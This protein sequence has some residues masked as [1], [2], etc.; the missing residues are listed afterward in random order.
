MPGVVQPGGSRG[1]PPPPPDG[2]HRDELSEEDRRTLIVGGWAQD[3]KKQTM[4]EESRMF[5][6]RDGVKNLVDQKELIVWGPRR[7]FGVLKFQLRE[8]EEPKEMRDR[9]WGVIQAARGSPVS[10]PST[11]SLGATKN[12][13]CSFT[14]TREAR[15]RSAHASMIRRVCLSMV[16]DARANSEANPNRA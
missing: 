15:K 1:D 11:T 7:S 10:L 13:W 6:E 12:L 14:K 4:L 2:G 5:L 16:G 3:S 8:G 9:M